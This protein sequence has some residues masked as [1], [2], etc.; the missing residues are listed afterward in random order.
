MV[1]ES[2]CLVTDHGRVHWVTAPTARI[3][4]DLAE[5]DRTRR[6]T[7]HVSQLGAGGNFHHIVHC[8]SD[9]AIIRSMVSHI[10]LDAGV[11]LAPVSW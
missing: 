5:R 11:A 10:L 8:A 9:P 2:C 4:A 3:V 6:R 7:H 1:V